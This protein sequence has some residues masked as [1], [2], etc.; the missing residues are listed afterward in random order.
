M[1]ASNVQF[2]W[3]HLQN[4]RVEQEKLCLMLH[5]P[6]PIVEPLECKLKGGRER[7]GGV[8]R[9]IREERREGERRG[10]GEEE[11]EGEREG[12]RVGG[13]DG[14]KGEVTHIII[15]VISDVVTTH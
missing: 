8:N 13:E 14:G 7:E 1:V 10:R 15:M 4:T 12:E 5:V 2:D 11:K 3:V 9:E 6:H